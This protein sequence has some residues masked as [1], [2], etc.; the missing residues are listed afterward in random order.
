MSYPNLE[1]ADLRK[2]YDEM[3][4]EDKE[5]EHVLAALSSVLRE[6]ASD[7]VELIPKLGTYEPGDPLEVVSAHLTLAI[8]ALGKVHS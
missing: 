7:V 5:T 3:N 4:A 2:A 6:V 8:A 1:N